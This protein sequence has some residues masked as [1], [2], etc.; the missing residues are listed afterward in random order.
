MHRRSPICAPPEV[1]RIAV[2]SH[3]HQHAMRAFREGAAE[4]LRW[5]SGAGRPWHGST[6]RDTMGRMA[7]V[8]ANPAAA[9]SFWA[10]VGV[11]GIGERV[12]IVRRDLRARAWR[13]RHDAGTYYWVLTG[14]FGGLAAGLALAAIG[15]LRLPGPAL[16]LVVG[17]TIAWAGMLVRFWAV[18]IL[19]ELFTTR[20]VVL[21]DQRVVSSGPYG[22]VR[23]PSYLGLLI[24]FFGLGLALGSPASA[25][26]MVAIPAVGIVKRIRVE[27]AALV[28]A[29]GSSYVRYC[30]GRA[31][32]LPGVW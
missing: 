14:V 16:W 29:L 8:F 17:L 20:V 9:M 32:L 18:V 11:W 4:L 21:K 3:L 26:A 22:Y 7:A 6:R 31:R 13:S 5:T 1:H 30:E 28:T 24:M 23:H 19:A 2:G 25:L 27:E 15:I 12:L 10:T